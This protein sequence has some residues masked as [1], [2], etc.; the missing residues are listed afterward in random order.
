MTIS[1]ARVL[2]N[3][4]NL[5]RTKTSVD[6]SA[7]QKYLNMGSA[8]IKKTP[9][10]GIFMHALPIYGSFDAPATHIWLFLCARLRQLKFPFHCLISLLPAGCQQV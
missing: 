4:A 9:Y 1:D 7:Y 3:W 6:E 10:M 2:H 5:L 8:C